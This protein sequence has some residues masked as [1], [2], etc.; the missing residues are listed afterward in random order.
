M[1]ALR[2]NGK[3]YIFAMLDQTSK[4]ISF[5]PYVRGHKN[6]LLVFI[7][8]ILSHLGLRKKQSSSPMDTISIMACGKFI[9]METCFIFAYLPMFHL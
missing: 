8:V 7:Y 1:I 3:P 2:N 9:T 4:S 5:A 6:K